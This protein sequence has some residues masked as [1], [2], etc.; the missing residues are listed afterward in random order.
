MVAEMSV[1]PDSQGMPQ[2]NYRM[3]A[4]ADTTALKLRE[5]LGVAR[6]ARR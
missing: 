6:A 5:R 2:P 3:H 1:V 4:T